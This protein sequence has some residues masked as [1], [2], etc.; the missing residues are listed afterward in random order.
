[1][2]AGALLQLASFHKL[3]VRSQTRSLP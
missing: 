1:M 3:Q 2:S